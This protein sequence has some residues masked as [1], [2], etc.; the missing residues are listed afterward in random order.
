[1]TPEL[2]DRPAFLVMGI[3]V[4]LDDPMTADYSAIWGQQFGPRAAEIAPHSSEEAAFGVYFP[5]EKEGADDFVAGMA[6]SGVVAP[7]AGLVLREVPAAREAVFQSNLSDLGAT[8]QHIFTEWLPNSGYE[9][10][11]GGP[12]FERFPPGCHEGT[13]PVTIHVPVR[14]RDAS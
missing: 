7:P 5:A 6:V 9:H 11:Q 14:K 13:A 4:R 8:W 3:Q 12:P 1:M 10:V 2:R